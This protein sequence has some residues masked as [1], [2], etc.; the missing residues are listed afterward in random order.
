MVD[1]ISSFFCNATS[2]YEV[3]LYHN[4]FTGTFPKCLANASSLSALDIQ[5]NKLH[6]TLPDTFHRW[7][8]L[9]ALN[10]NGNQFEGLL[11]KS[12][13]NCTNFVDLNLGNNQFED[14]F[15]NWLQ[16]LTELEILVLRG[17]K[18]GA[19]PKAYIQ[20]FQA[21][22]IL[23][24]KVPD[25]WTYYIQ[26]GIS[27]SCSYNGETM[28]EPRYDDSVS[29][30]IKGANTLFAKIPTV[31]VI[32][33]LSKNNFE[34]NIPDVIIG[35]LHGL[36][37]LNLSHNRLVGHIPHSLGNLTNL[38]SLD[39]SSNMLSGKIPSELT[40][41]KFLEAL[42]ISQNQLVGSIPKGKQFD[43]FS[44]DSYLENM[45]LCG[46][47]LSIQ[48]NSG[49]PQQQYPPSEDKFG[50]GWKPVAIGYAC[51]TVLGIGLGSCVFWIGKPEWLVIIFGGTTT[52][53]KRRNRG[54]RRARRT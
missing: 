9:E 11:P 48:C 25:D 12:L 30:T 18:F 46:F 43:T 21:M 4:N 32:I 26:T 28:S 51:G 22:K 7:Y 15:P 14:T 19:L 10:V 20:N 29:V 45:G 54:N 37:D 8:L 2:F 53:I 35:E 6:G 40:N 1:D 33:D 5:M 42:N 52:R 39:L 47:P 27:G 31:F 38:E 34:G 41:L 17:N 3:N 24:D 23:D 36:K 49:V 16:N 13:S 44:N 50:F